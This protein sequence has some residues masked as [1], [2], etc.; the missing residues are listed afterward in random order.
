MDS[1]QAKGFSGKLPKLNSVNFSQWKIRL[2]DLFLN[3][4]QMIGSLNQDVPV[5]TYIKENS[6]L[7]Y[8]SERLNL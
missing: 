7:A 3:E 4:N 5:I 2:H 1:D 8:L 6:L